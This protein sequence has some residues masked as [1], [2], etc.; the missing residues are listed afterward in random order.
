[1]KKFLFVEDA[2]VP[3]R[4]MFFSIGDSPIMDKAEQEVRAWYAQFDA[5]F[6]LSPAACHGF[7]RVGIAY[8]TM[9]DISYPERIDW[10]VFLNTAG[11]G[12]SVEFLVNAFE[13]NETEVMWTRFFDKLVS[14]FG[15]FRATYLGKGFPIFKKVLNRRMKSLW[16]KQ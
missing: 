4:S 6:A 7:D 2:M 5:I 1:M 16:G 9:E 14:N 12:F 10:D 11:Q 3:A 8:L 15:V 13:M